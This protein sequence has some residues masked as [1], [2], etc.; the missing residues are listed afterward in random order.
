M[1][2]QFLE[3]YRASIRSATDLMKLSL[4]Q[5]E[6]L[7]Q[8]QL[9]LMRSA[10]EENARSS[11]QAGE[12]KSLDDMVTLN[13]RLAG[14]QLERMAEFWSNWWRAAGETQ[15]S[16]IDQM[17]SQV[18]QAKDRA[19]EGYAFTGRAAEEATAPRERKTP[20]NRKGA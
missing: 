12:L 6:R 16:M 1:Q 19:R 14:V 3:L 4:E 2:A 17:Q 5:T 15:K 11:G 10:L 20:E 18:G 7:Q 13:S 8:Q 9:Q